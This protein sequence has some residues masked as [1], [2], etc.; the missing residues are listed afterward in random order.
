MKIRSW[1]EIKKNYLDYPEQDWSY[2]TIT[3][4]VDYKNRQSKQ[5]KISGSKEKYYK[6]YCIF[7]EEGY[8]G[9]KIFIS[10]SEVP[11]YYSDITLQFTKSI[12]KN[13]TIKIKH[14]KKR[15]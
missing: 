4:T 5:V 13:G 11:R 2:W 12:K 7:G 15:K 14:T 10:K 6:D 3:Y 1:E 8:K 9:I